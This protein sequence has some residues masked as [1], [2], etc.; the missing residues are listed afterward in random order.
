M[1]FQLVDD[2][3]PVSVTRG[4]VCSFCGSGLRVLYPGGRRER[5]VRT[6][7]ELDDHDNVYTFVSI[8]ESC[9]WELGGL[10]GMV[11][12]D[13]AGWL[14]NRVDELTAE[15]TACRTSGETLS[16]SDLTQFADA[17]GATIATLRDHRDLAYATAS[18]TDTAAGSA[19]ADG[20]YAAPVKRPPGR[21]RGP[22][23]RP[24]G[25]SGQPR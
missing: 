24:R 3:G 17:I 18:A 9:C 25:Q 12:A 14:Q 15:L 22:N 8:C 7:L 10:V 2:Y 11:T 5:V 1:T 13:R 16:P 19:S 21:P 23:Y 4:G 20:T 6:D